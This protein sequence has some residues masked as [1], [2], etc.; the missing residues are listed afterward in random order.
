MDPLQ[1]FTDFVHTP[2]VP[3]LATRAYTR[4]GTAQA[5]PFQKSP[6]QGE[7]VQKR[8]GNEGCVVVPTVTVGTRKPC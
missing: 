2:M 6:L 7:P 1:E 3:S 5:Q 4:E 8:E